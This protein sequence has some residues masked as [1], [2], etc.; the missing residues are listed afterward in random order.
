M[1]TNGRDYV[2]ER[3]ILTPGIILMAAF[4]VAVALW[5]NRRSDKVA[6]VL[7]I[8]AC[9][10]MIA[11]LKIFPWDYLQSHCLLGSLS[12]QVQFPWRYVGIVT[13][14]LTL[15]LGRLL[16]R[17]ANVRWKM[18]LCEKSIILVGFV[19]T[20]FLTSS[21]LDDSVF[22][23][24]YDGA[25][26]DDFQIGTGEYLREGTNRANFSLSIT[27][28]VNSE[29][30]SEVSVLSRRG[31]S[32]ELHCVGTDE[33]GV[34]WLPMFN[35]KGYHATDGNGKEY[36]ISDG[37]DNRIELSLPAG[38][39]GSIFVEY[40]EPWYWRVAE[41]ISLASVLGVWM[42]SRRQGIARSVSAFAHFRKEQ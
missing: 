2:N 16:T 20:C 39:E 27:S 5:A 9:L 42:I 38:F 23:T 25:E 18:F 10:A 6:G 36:P 17:I 11:T 4:V 30:M 34:V 32:M 21:Y 41:L 12:V 28:K 8:Y 33:E 3:M 14:I 37:Y 7:I 24:N 31:S 29:R 1:L 35:Y 22:I 13:V 40:R 15:L 19:M 26:L